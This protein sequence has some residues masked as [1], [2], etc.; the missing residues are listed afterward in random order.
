MII[1][2]RDFLLKLNLRQDSCA[3]PTEPNRRIKSLKRKQ[4]GKI[5]PI[6]LL[7]TAIFTCFN[8]PKNKNAKH[9]NSLSKPAFSRT[10][11]IKRGIFIA[12][13]LSFFL[14]CFLQWNNWRK[15]EIILK[16]VKR[17]KRKSCLLADRQQFYFR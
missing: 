13:F 11:D 7:S 16:T 12:V 3:L 10:L 8:R 5:T 4:G 2:M 15:A 14:S 17:C 1:Q 9:N 6:V